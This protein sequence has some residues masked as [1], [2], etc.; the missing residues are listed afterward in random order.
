MSNK[1]YLNGKYREI[2][3]KNPD[4]PYFKRNIFLSP[5]DAIDR[6]Y[7]LNDK[8]N[9]VYMSVYGYHESVQS[10]KDIVDNNIVF[11][12]LVYD[13]DI[14]DKD[15]KALLSLNGYTSVD[16]SDMS[17][18]A[19]S[20][21]ADKI[22]TEEMNDV[23]EC[24]DDDAVMDY[25]YKKYEHDYLTDPIKECQKVARWFKDKFHVDGLLFFSGG[26]G[27]H[28]HILLNNPIE[29]KNVKEVTTFIGD[30]LKKSLKLKTIDSSVYKD[31]VRVIRMPTSRHQGTKLYAN[32]FQI[33]DT[34]L[35]IIDN[36]VIRTDLS[37]ITIPDNDTSNLED[38][39]KI[40]D[41]EQSS[42]K[43]NKAISHEIKDDAG[44][45]IN[46]EIPI[47][48]DGI[49]KDNFLKVYKKGQMNIIGHRLIHLFYRSH[50]PEDDVYKFFNSLQVDH[51]IDEVNR[52][53]DRTY[54]L[55]IGHDHIG[56]LN[57]FIDGIT[58]YSSDDDRESL[59]AYFKGYFIKKDKTEDISLKSF[60]IGKDEY[61]SEVTAK[62]VNGLI[63]EIT[64]KD[65]IKKESGFNFILVYGKTAKFQVIL[66]DNVYDFMIS[67]QYNDKGFKFKN[68]K[69]LKDIESMLTD[70]YAVPKWPKS[71]IN[72]LT[73][74]LSD[75]YDFIIETNKPDETEILL[76]SVKSSPTDTSNLINLAE[77]IEN[78]L[79]VKRTSDKKS[80]H[81]YLN[82]NPNDFN[83]P[84]MDLLT[85][86]TLGYIL[87]RDYNIRLPDKNIETV[88]KS[89]HGRH[90][91]N[92]TSWEFKDGYYLETDNNYQVVGHDPLITSK[93]IGIKQDD[94]FYFYEYKPDVKFY[95]IPED[96]TLIE[97]TLKQILI[98][99]TASVHI[100]EDKDD[101]HKYIVYDNPE[102]T[103]LY[104]DFLQR[105]GASFNS[106]NV[107]KK[108]TMYLGTGDNG[109]SLIS[110]ILRLVFN[111][112]YY[113]FTPKQLKTDA[114]T[115]SMASGK[116]VL[117][118][119]ELTK[120]SLNGLWDIVKRYSSGLDNT[121]KRTMYSDDTDEMSSYGLLYIFTNII[122]DMPTDDKAVLRRV[123]ILTLPN[124]FTDNPTAD[125]EYPIINDL[126]IR[127]G[128]D[129]KGLEWLV[130]A[131][132]KAYKS[133]HKFM[134][135]QTDIETL[136]IVKETDNLFNY[137]YTNTELS[138]GSQ[139]YVHQLLDGFKEYSDEQGY[140]IKM[141]DSELRQEI[142]KK[143]RQIYSP[144][145]LET[146]KHQKGRRWYNI[147]IK[148]KDEIEK[149]QTVKW[150]VNEYIDSPEEWQVSGIERTVYNQ[151]KEHTAMSISDIKKLH[152]KIDVETIINNL[153]DNGYLIKYE[154]T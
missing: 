55:D 117:I 70:D 52:W 32:Q 78:E 134:A 98:P 94:K 145:E 144:N 34:Y 116:N 124:V 30:N 81:Y 73:V 90:K 86:S 56:G 101:G 20:S 28:L 128:N 80:S 48:D 13:F 125:N 46:H 12:R 57:Y 3:Y 152:P 33:N 40:I 76:S 99:K 135:S 37:S 25:Y 24:S 68:K 138:Y 64:F 62:L 79:S 87:L 113:G 49:F 22:R 1:L 61:Q 2:G 142:G 63:S 9:N 92:T 127:L 105:L 6:L 93:K 44:Y 47:Y 72:N 147:R 129:L 102:D 19:I 112:F 18:D 45:D 42:I 131:G 151:I 35:D 122:P 39:I 130:N 139:T 65:L 132:I 85:T 29:V 54:H 96:E 53:I 111:D 74:Y 103:K 26:K 83:S 148:S 91:I 84:T 31:K 121:T 77:F 23:S 15:D 43:K 21:I 67:Y 109:K 126:D 136:S 88:L 5:D 11:D 36:A 115:E 75:L 59:I 7:D 137:L 114:F 69:D 123:D 41:D 153:V 4:N 51:N 104:I 108:V 16:L 107:H 149:E 140:V 38:W 150:S 143:V 97:R 154:I 133:S 50:V 10:S 146:N 106:R 71:M 119:D 100:K 118:M 82:T 58:E 141:T 17:E 14:D 89:I 8:G 120:D 66:N 60:K 95:N 110:Y 27:C